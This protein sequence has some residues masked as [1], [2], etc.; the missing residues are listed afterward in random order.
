MGMWPNS[1]SKDY[2]KVWDMKDQK[3]MIKCQ[4][5]KMNDWTHSCED[6][7]ASEIHNDHEICHFWC[8]DPR[9]VEVKEEELYQSAMDI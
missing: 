7:Y 6:P 8:D 4:V 1:S 3:T 5:C 2:E 9:C